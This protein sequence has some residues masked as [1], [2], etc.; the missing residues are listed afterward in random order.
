MTVGQNGD[1]E[2]DDVWQQT[3]SSLDG[4]ITAR[5]LEVKRNVVDGDEAGAV[6]GRG[7]DEQQHCV[8]VSHEMAAEQAGRCRRE[9]GV[10]LLESKGDEQDTGDDKESDDL[11]TVPSVESATKVDAHN[12]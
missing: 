7:A 2:N 5:K 6:T 1:T 3:N 8:P 9:D 12:E 10:G 4:A 11:T